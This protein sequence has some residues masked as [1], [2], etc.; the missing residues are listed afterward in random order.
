MSDTTVTHKP[1]S[2]RPVWVAPAL[3]ATAYLA[4]WQIAPRIRA[5]SEGAVVV[6]TMIALA[7]VVWF[8]AAFARSV[9]STRGVLANVLA[10]ALVSVPIIVIILANRGMPVWL[11]PILA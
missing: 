8:T 1:E 7:L 10:S 9:R 3:L 4:Y 11:A 6:S 2:A 5:E